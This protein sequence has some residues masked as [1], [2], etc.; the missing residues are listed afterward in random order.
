MKLNLNFFILLFLLWPGSTSAQQP[1]FKELTIDPQNDNIKA[2]SIF[3][4]KDEIIY[5]GTDN[6]LCRFDGF[7]FTKLEFP[8]QV[9][10]KHVKYI[11]NV[12]NEL[13]SCMHDGVIVA[14]AKGQ[15][16][17]VN[18]PIKSPISS[19]LQLNKETLWI[20]TYGEGIF[21]KTGRDWHRL[22]GI[23]DPYIYQI[24]KHP[25]GLILAG[26]D[27]GLIVINP[28]TNPI[29]YRVYNSKNGLPDN[30]VKTIGVQPDGRV[31]LGLQEQGLFHF[32]LKD[33]SLTN[34]G[35]MERLIQL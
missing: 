30:I 26:S 14:I 9:I 27:G 6:G 28:S 19:V 7:N 15:K 1:F 16:R 11:T 21:Y 18:S 32:D 20:S 8:K 12:N 17:I 5:V 13:W 10:S 34:P 23:P 35:N 25:S 4:D 29:S 24:V 31:L 22:T 2:T 33:K 3:Q